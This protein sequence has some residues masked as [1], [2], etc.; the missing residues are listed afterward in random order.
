MKRKIGWMTFI[1]VAVVMVATLWAGSSALA[2]GETAKGDTPKKET[3]TTIDLLP[4][5]V[6]VVVLEQVG[7]GEILGIR[8]GVIE[9]TKV[10]R[11]AW[12]SGDQMTNEVT[13]SVDGKV[14]SQMAR[15]EGGIDDEDEEE[16]E[17]EVSM[18]ELPDAAKAT[19]LK[20]A[21]DHELV[22]LEEVIYKGRTFYDAEWLDGGMEVEITVTPEGE[23][24]GREIETH[25]DETEDDEGDD[26]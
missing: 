21:G 16:A 18:D 22:E 4:E 13:I 3:E 17:R 12:T 26:D 15:A 2:D 10:Y 8:E 6:R 25:D 5:A 11:V 20:E 24:V 9:K 14:L 7:D 1:A 19:I 23:I